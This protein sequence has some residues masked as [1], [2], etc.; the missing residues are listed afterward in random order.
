MESDM[1][2][3]KIIRAAIL[4]LAFLFSGCGDKIEPGN[5]K[6]EGAA[7]VKTPVSEM[8]Y[9]SMPLFYEAMGTVH[10]KTSGTLSSKLMG[11]VRAVNVREGDFIKKGDILV[12]I[13][14]SQVQ[15]RLSQAEEA[16]AGAQKEYAASVSAADSARAASE[17]ARA[18]YD[19]Y[20]NLLRE[21]SASRQEFEEA[22]ARSRQAEAA[23][24]HA[25]SMVQAAGHRI[26]QAEA[27]LASA[28]SFKK[29]SVITA[30]YD[31]LVTAKMAEAGDLASPGS[32]LLG[33]EGR[34]GYYIELVVPEKHVRNAGIG[35]KVTANIP[36]LND[37][38]FEGM[39][40]ALVTAADS[41][42]RSFLV[43][44]D[45]KA[46][47]NVHTGMYARVQIPSEEVRILLIPSSALVY[48]GQLTGLYVIDDAQK[49]R[50]RVLR[51]GKSFGQSV[52]ILSG[53]KPGDRYLPD[54]PPNMADGIRV[55]A[56]S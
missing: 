56:V 4:M 45:F 32:A 28:K 8:Q 27:A 47:D 54:P 16:K 43:K 18:T 21:E 26:K 29:D 17:L 40:S 25:E 23:L 15:A 20:L 52:E 37:L 1:L 31:A 41:K 11:I 3:R 36:A 22:E 6:K 30:P 55:E 34:E 9:T 2:Q 19:R 53:L 35:K 44:I 46:H 49:A 5:A 38:S 7:S 33:I 51:T 48:Q 50:Y 14:D 39:I 24:S 13:D 10:A 12:L 42:T